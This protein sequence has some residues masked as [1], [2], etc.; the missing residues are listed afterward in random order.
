[1]QRG[2]KFSSVIIQGATSALPELNTFSDT[3]LIMYRADGHAPSAVPT[4]S[5]L[6]F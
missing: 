5:A 3:L 2:T 4:S 6:I 1:M